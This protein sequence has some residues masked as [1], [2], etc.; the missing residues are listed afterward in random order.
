MWLK[1]WVI[2]NGHFEIFG[3]SLKEMGRCMMSSYFLPWWHHICCWLFYQW[4]SSIATLMEELF[5]PQRRLCW[6]KTSFGHIPWEYLGQFMNFSADLCTSCLLTSVR[7]DAISISEIILTNIPIFV[8]SDIMFDINYENIIPNNTLYHS[9]EL[10]LVTLTGYQSWFQETLMYWLTTFK[11]ECQNRLTKALEI[12]KDV[13]YQGC[14]CHANSFDLLDFSKWNRWDKDWLF[15]IF[16]IFPQMKNLKV[17]Y[18][19]VI[20]FLDISL[21]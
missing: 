5:G 19:C 4:D 18:V 6:K 1:L 14:H 3:V 2:P 10:F 21:N 13:S 15:L 9:R 16:R 7:V 17:K 8:F 11:V 20:W 12:D